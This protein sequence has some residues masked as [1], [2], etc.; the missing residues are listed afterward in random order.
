[1]CVCRDLRIYTDV[2]RWTGRVEE[3]A[4]ADLELIESEVSPRSVRYWQ[5]TRFAE[6]TQT[7]QRYSPLGGGDMKDI[8]GSE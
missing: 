6:A 7:E 1:V 2:E 3:Y 5:Q 8:G 4:R